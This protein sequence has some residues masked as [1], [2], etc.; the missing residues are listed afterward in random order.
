MNDEIKNY[1]KSYY[2]VYFGINA[3][4]ERWAKERGLTSN[5]LFV[6]YVIHAYPDQCTQRLICEKLLIPK[7]TVNTILSSFGKKGYIRKEIAGDD[8]RNKFI[9]F[10]EEGQKYA[11]LLLTD[12]LHFEESALMNMSSDERASMMKG[13]LAFLEQ[14]T[15]ALNVLEQPVPTSLSAK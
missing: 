7:Q 14:L 4:Y 10:T 9:L 12:M 11:D 15:R 13:S 1:I 8:K 2:D 3:L 5:A 6:L